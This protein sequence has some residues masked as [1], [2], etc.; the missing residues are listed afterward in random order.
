MTLKIPEYINNIAPYVAGKTIDEVER[1]Y[2][3][4]DSVKLASNENP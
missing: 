1:E 3:I 2:G 4:S